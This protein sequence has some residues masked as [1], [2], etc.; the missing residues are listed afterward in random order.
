MS[1]TLNAKKRKYWPF[2]KPN[3][4]SFHKNVYSNNQPSLL[5]ISNRTWKKKFLESF[6]PYIGA[7]K[8]SGFKK[9]LYIYLM[10][11]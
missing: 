2:R 6:L 4:Y 1:V 3:D 7:I 11:I 8:Q 5:N 9:D 10:Y